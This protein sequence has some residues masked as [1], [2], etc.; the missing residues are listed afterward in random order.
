[1]V[2][3]DLVSGSMLGV[4]ALDREEQP[5]GGGGAIRDGQGLV[6]SSRVP[7]TGG[8]DHIAVAIPASE[9]EVG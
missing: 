3:Y 7:W 9:E 5:P 1:M 8:G 4:L 6:E 2:A